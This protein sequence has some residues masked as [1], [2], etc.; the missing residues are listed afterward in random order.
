MLHIDAPANHTG[1]PL[2]EQE[3]PA[4]T[5]PPLFGQPATLNSLR[6]DEACCAQ[7]GATHGMG[8]THCSHYSAGKANQHTVQLASKTMRQKRYL[9]LAVLLLA[10]IFYWP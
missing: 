10:L 6:F 7:C 8:Q 1:H 9:M 5:P 2:V 4:P 3:Q